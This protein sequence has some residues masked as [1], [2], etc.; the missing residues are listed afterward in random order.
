MGFGSLQISA[1]CIALGLKAP[2]DVVWWPKDT[3]PAEELCRFLEVAPQCYRE[4]RI[5]TP[6]D[7][8]PMAAPA[9]RLLLHEGPEHCRQVASAVVQCAEIDSE[10]LW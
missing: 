10:M 8:L 6:P 5:C 1:E 2:F 7:A 4:F 9:V 3:S